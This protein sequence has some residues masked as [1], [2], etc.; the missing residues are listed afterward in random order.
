MLG[1]CKT[2]MVMKKNKEYQ[3]RYP[4]LLYFFYVYSLYICSNSD[5]ILNT[6]FIIVFSFS[7][8]IIRKLITLCSPTNCT[9]LFVLFWFSYCTIITTFF[10]FSFMLY[11]ISTNPVF[12]VSFFVQYYICT[13]ISMI[14]FVYKIG[15]Y[16]QLLVIRIIN[17]YYTCKY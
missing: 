9:C 11:F 12:H 8:I 2:K 16:E 15:Y 4:R 5:Y 13:V 14:L 1:L 3:Y 7:I 6:L 17:K 10:G